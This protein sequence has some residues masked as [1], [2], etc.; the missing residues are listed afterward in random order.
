MKSCIVVIPVYK[1]APELTELASFRQ[2]IKVL[3][4][5]DLCLVTYKE[6]DLTVYKGIAKEYAK[7]IKVNYFNHCFFTSV[8]GTINC[9]IILIFIQ[10]S[11]SMI[12][13]LYIS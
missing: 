13:C 3:K 11:V 7:E 4:S 5:F 9:A 12:T 6:L 1:A 10:P 2:C 8:A